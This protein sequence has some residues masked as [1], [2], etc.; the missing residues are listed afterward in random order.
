ML[1]VHLRILCVALLLFAAPPLFIHAE[2]ADD[3]LQ[4]VEIDQSE[5][6]A[7][8]TSAQPVAEAQ[9]LP[10]ANVRRTYLPIA[11][12][13]T[14]V[15]I[16]FSAGTSTACQPFTPGTRFS[17]ITFLCYQISIGGGKGKTYRTEWYLNGKPQ[18]A[19]NRSGTV[20]YDSELRSG[21]VC[22]GPFGN[23]GDPLPRG[24]WQ[25]NVFL[26]GQLYKQATATIS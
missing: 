9:A 7:T 17:N 2:E 3:A 12:T 21:A 25:V 15:S 18:T 14:A 5:Q 16:R 6:P 26:N 10:A 13:P 11:T 23:C 20:V 8:I 4:L 24:L 19:L 1:I 22:Y